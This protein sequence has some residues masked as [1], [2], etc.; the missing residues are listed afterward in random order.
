MA[1]SST[2]SLMPAVIGLV[3]TTIGAILG[4]CGRLITQLFLEKRKQTYE[5]QKETRRKKQEKLEE[6]ASALADHLHWINLARTSPQIE[7]NFQLLFHELPHPPFTK[8][9]AICTVYFLQ[10]E[11][12]VDAVVNATNA[13]FHSI[14]KDGPQEAD[15]TAN[16]VF[17]AAN[18]LNKA[19]NDYISREFQ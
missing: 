14:V 10:L 9:Y 1:D 17:E 13:F 16:R 12:E 2:I 15:L 18:Q 19:F 3:G 8:L 11:K 7:K 5:R 4:F 6:L